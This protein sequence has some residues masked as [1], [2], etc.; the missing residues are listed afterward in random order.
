MIQFAEV[1]PDQQIVVSLTRQLSWTHF[2]AL[3]SMK[4]PLQREFYAEMC[5]VE[6]WSVRTLREKIQGMLYERAAISRKP[7]ELVSQELDSLRDCD[8][9]TP[10]LV[11]RDPCL[12][13]F[14]GLSDIYSER[15]LESAI[16]KELERFLL[17]LGIDF[18]FVARQKRITIN[19][20]NYHLDLLFCHCGMRCLVAIE[21]KLGKFQAADKG[22]MEQYPRWRDKYEKRER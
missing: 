10:N 4:D 14:L 19:N 7:V 18:I 1:S 11:F 20:E 17:E 13:D 5:R 12:L 22:Q 8:R 9:M 21:L 16:L 6:R 15:D 2:V 3:I